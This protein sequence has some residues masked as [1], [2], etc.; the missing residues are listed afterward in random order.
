MFLHLSVILFTGRRS[1]SKGVS[2]QGV[3]VQGG[4]VSVQGGGV[5][6]QGVSVRG[7]SL[8]RGLSV[9]GVEGFL[10]KGGSLSEGE[11]SLSRVSLS[12]GV[13]VQG[14]GGVS[15]QGGLCQGQN[16]SVQIGPNTERT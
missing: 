1:L 7:V 9:Q 6:V 3:S 15:V 8:L 13:S 14:G 5:S 4:G 12:K 16:K 2:A 11:G 10:P